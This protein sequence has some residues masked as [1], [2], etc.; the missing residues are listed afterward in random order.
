MSKEFVLS[1][2]PGI[3][4]LGRAFED[5][6]F[7]IVRGPDL[8]YG[9]DIRRFVPPVGVF[10]GVIGGSPCQGFSGLN[11]NPDDY[12]LEMLAEFRRVVVV[13]RPQWYLLENVRGVPRIEIDGY[14]SQYIRLNAR[15]CGSIQSRNRIFQFGSLD[16]YA[17]K[18]ERV[19]RPTRKVSICLASEGKS[20]QRR[21][22]SEFCEA[23]DLPSDY[24]LPGWSLAAKYD[25]V[26]NGVPLKMGKTIAKAIR[27]RRYKIDDV[28]LCPCE[29]G[30]LLTGKQKSA[31]A[32]C[33][34]RLQRERRRKR[35]TPGNTKNANVTD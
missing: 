12:S 3:D 21:G 33:R 13:A 2:F 23:F 5:E 28:R 22:W 26:G 15:D 35:E 4:L 32:A 24:D 27:S 10:D 11:R 8:I 19:P 9:G 34:K 30:R 20:P 18:V 1:I 6:N 31:T 25:A 29:C 14:P 17:L 16:G 7:C